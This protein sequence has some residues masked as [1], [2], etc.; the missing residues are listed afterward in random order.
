[1]TDRYRRELTKLHGAELPEDLWDRVLEGP[2]LTPL[3]PRGRS[4]ATAAVVAFA[5]FGL[6]GFFLW[7]AFGEAPASQPAGSDVVGVPPSGE[8][9]AVFLADGRP[10]FVVHHQDG[11]VTVVDAFSSHRAWGVEELNVWCPSTRQFV[12]VAHEAHFDEY[13]DWSAGPAPGGLETFGFQVLE[14]DAAGDPASIR[15]TQQMFTPSPQGGEG[16]ERPPFCPAGDAEP[17]DADLVPVA[18]AYTG[19]TGMVLAHAI[20]DDQVWDSP[21]EAVAAAP[22]GWVAIRSTLHVD[23][24]G[25]VQLCAQVIDDRCE[26][27]VVVRGVDGVGLMVNVTRFDWVSGYEEPQVW[28]VQIRDGVIDNPAGVTNSIEPSA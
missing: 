9:S 21:A 28:L 13:G 22:T 4:R 18:G 20:D 23:S 5:I 12:E 27:G 3:A 2:R 10:V 16:P 1:M 19:E 24:D 26:G 25:F 14:T 7:R 8:T 17:G 15:V 6:A 11:T